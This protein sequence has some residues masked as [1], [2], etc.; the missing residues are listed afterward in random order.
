MEWK[1]EVSALAFLRLLI[2]GGTSGLFFVTPIAMYKK[3]YI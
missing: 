3:I 1:L 2:G